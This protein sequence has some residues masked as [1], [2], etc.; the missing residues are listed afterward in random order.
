MTDICVRTSLAGVPVNGLAADPEITIQ[1]A[2][3]GAAVVTDDAMTD[4][5]TEGLYT[6][7]FTPVAGLEYCFIVDA[8]PSATGQV[9]VRFFEGAFDNELNDIWNDRGLNPSVPKTITEVTLGE[10]YD[11]AVAAPTAIAQDVT[12]AGLVTTIDRT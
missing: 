4:T 6:Y 8:D 5:G 10:D 11:E 1:R 9:D 3:T 12:K 7:N 2:D